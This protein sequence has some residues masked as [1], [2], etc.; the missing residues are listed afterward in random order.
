MQHALVA[1][2]RWFRYL[3]SGIDANTVLTTRVLQKH[4]ST[5]SGGEGRGSVAL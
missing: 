5:G 4:N 3:N 2:T 1:S